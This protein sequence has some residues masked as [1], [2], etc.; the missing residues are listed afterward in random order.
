V[1]FL[2]VI[3]GNGQVRVDPEVIKDWPIPKQKK[4]VQAFL[5]FCNFYHQKGFRKITKPVMSLTRNA[6]FV[7]GVPQQLDYKKL[8]EGVAVE[9][10]SFV[11]QDNG[12]FRVEADTSNYAMGAVLLQFID[13]KW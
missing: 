8:E 7:W 4:D 13:G 6:D 11:P 5:R 12:K 2:G 1:E 10:I 3:V 9:T